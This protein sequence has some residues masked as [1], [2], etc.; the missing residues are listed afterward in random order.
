MSSLGVYFGP[1]AIVIIEARG[2]A[3]LNN[4]KIPLSAFSSD[5]LEEKVPDEIKMVA[6]FKDELRRNKIN[7]KEAYLALSGRDL[8]VRTFEM[9][10][11]PREELVS[12]IRFEASKHVPFKIEELVL[13]YQVNF[14]KITNKNI[15]LLIGIKKEALAKYVSIFQQLNLK[16]SAIEHAGFSVLKLLGPV[17]V[18]AKGVVSVLNA[19]LIEHDE[20]NFIVTE[21]NFPL[22]S[23]DML[24]KSELDNGQAEGQSQGML[25]EKLKTEI[26]VSLDYYHR[27][28]P[29][30]QISRHLVILNKDY[31]AD[32]EAFAKEI[33]INIEFVNTAKFFAKPAPF[34]LAL[35]KAYAVS[36]SKALGVAFKIDLFTAVAREKAARQ[37]SQVSQG[38]SALYKDLRVDARVLV[39]AVL[40]CLGALGFG[41]YQKLPVQKDL[42]TIISMRPVVPGINANASFEKLS[43]V[44]AEYVEKLQKLDKLIK[45]ELH[46]TE[47]LNLLPRL[48]PDGVW[49]QQFSFNKTG[50]EVGL[51]LQGMAYAGDSNKE[52]ELVNDF[53]G[54]LK[55]DEFFGKYFKDI[56]IVS[57]DRG[58]LKDA[59]VTQFNIICRNRNNSA[60]E[61]AE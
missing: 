36:L 15:V 61:D 35:V 16:I 41:L 20:V 51:E 8:I 26:R 22:F 43:A 24:L 38:L 10:V 40:I 6:L 28:F 21:D 31:Q 47:S 29:S 55:G 2:R 42:N 32:M 30:K 13:D 19:D 33:G 5:K 37:K 17:G 18:K 11:M 60:K 7:A 49:L 53:L 58:T 4:I 3:I 46:V 50:A 54:K 52:F 45:E 12:A 25:L 39:L 14:N 56:A 34:S 27:N 23:R 59:A 9:P 48:L 57:L 44:N 1:E